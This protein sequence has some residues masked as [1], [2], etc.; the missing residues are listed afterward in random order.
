MARKFKNIDQLQRN[1][2]IEGIIG[3]PVGLPGGITLQVLCATDANPRWAAN[4]EKFS[5]EVRRLSR[6]NVPDDRT[7]KFLAEQFTRLFIIGWEGVK[8]DDGNGGEVDVPFSADA[9]VDFLLATDDA[10][11][12]LQQVVYDTK[13]FRGERI[14]I[15]ANSLKN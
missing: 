2:E 1:R 3:T 8:E 15:I 12:A 11:P 5:A 7:R 6:A 10:L 14:E 4:G 13:M 9:C